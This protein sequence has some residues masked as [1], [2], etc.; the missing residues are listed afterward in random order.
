MEEVKAYIESG[1]LELYVLGQLSAEECSEVAAMAQ[2]HPEVKAEIL[3]IELAMETYALQNAVEPSANIEDQIFAK[4]AEPKIVPLYDNNDGKVRKLR[5]ALVAC[6]ILLAI[7]IG[8]LFSAHKE[9][10]DANFQI[11]ALNSDKEKFAQTVSQL[12]FQNAGM[13]NRI[14]MTKTDE[15]TTVK[16]AGVKTSPKAEMLVYWNKVNKN[17]LINYAAM[18]LPKTDQAHEYQLW[19]LVDGKPVSLGIFGDSERAK[20]AVKQMDAIE[21]AQAFAVTIEPVGGSVNPTMEKMVVM[22]AI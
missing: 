20:D 17:I 11:T 4:I 16:L 19:A 12:E 3:A 8:A 1:I 7:S 22:G 10:K 15:W 21:K 6:S 18:D 13:E 2:K 14:A 9:L 5:Y